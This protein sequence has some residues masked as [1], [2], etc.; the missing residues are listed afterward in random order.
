MVCARIFFFVCSY[1]VEHE[2]PEKNLVTP[3][4]LVLEARI[5][6]LPLPVPIPNAFVKSE[7]LKNGSSYYLNA[8]LP[9]SSSDYNC[10]FLL[11]LFVLFF[12]QGLSF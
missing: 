4:G 7:L 3:H 8:F 1:L 6:N 5:S 11:L 2:E 10:I 12:R 9:C